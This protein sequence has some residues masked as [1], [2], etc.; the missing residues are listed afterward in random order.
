[1]ELFHSC[2]KSWNKVGTFTNIETIMKHYQSDKWEY[3]SFRPN[4]SFID[5][6]MVTT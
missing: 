6:I 3:G 5:R 1:M 4:G 2:G